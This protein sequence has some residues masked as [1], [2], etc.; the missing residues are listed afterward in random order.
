MLIL[1]LIVALLAQVV[2]LAIGALIEVSDYGFL[3]A[4]LTVSALMCHGCINILR[5]ASILKFERRKYGSILDSLYS[6][7]ES[8][9][10]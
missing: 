9:L 3:S 1:V 8:N 6:I 2:V 5:Q 10:L 4:V 7:L